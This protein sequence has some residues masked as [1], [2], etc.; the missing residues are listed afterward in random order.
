MR[1][2]KS[3][4]KG[5]PNPQFTRKSFVLLDGYWDF[6]FDDNDEGIINKWYQNFPKAHKILVP[7]AYQTI[8]SEI[9]IQ[10]PHNIVWYHKEF[11]HKTSNK[12]CILNFEGVDYQSDVYINGEHIGSNVGAYHRFSFDIT[13]FLKDGKNDITVRVYDDYS[14]L[15]PR[16]KQRWMDE[17]YECFYVDTTGIYKSVW[18]EYVGLTYLK[19]VK[20]TP[21]IDTNLVTFDYDIDGNLDNIYVETIITYNDKLISKSIN[22][23]N[24]PQMTLS[25]DF[26]TDSATMKVAYWSP[27]SPNLY[28]VE[29]RILKDNEVIDEVLSYFGAV[30]Y[31]AIGNSIYINHAPFYLKLILDQGYWKDSGMTS[32]EEKIIKDIKLM[33]D[34]GLNGCRKHE[35]IESDLFYYYCDILGYLLWQELPSPYEFRDQTIENAT[36]E[37]IK[38][39][40]Q[41][42]N[43]PSLMTH[44]I[45]NESWGLMGIGKNK[46]QQELTVGLYHLTKSLDPTRFVISNDGWEHTK[47]DILTVHNYEQDASKLKEEYVNF[48]EI[49]AK[50]QRHAHRGTKRLLADS[51]EYEGQPVVFSEFAGIAF[52]K[53]TNKGWGYGNSV[54]D[55]QD[56]LN[57]LESQINVIESN[58]AFSGYCITQLSD[59]EQEVNGLVDENRNY[60]ADKVKLRLIIAKK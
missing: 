28:D 11:E 36:N 1:H 5:H 35:K 20:I 13:K 23:V 8:K 25:M 30:S 7:Y 49:F 22:K 40:K 16:G 56:F 57:R 44:V 48:T 38:I 46:R 29:F 9:N 14:C 27:Y 12:R 3:Y 6:A 24:R 4:L 43:H 37:W 50:N 34:I 41:H 45:F 42:Y 32:D 31:E 26:S 47:S 21:D 18:I 2:T 39:V 33:Q 51:Y 15:R 52:E 10:E 53:D 55:E 54:K 58:H 17:S 19:S 60:K 59:V